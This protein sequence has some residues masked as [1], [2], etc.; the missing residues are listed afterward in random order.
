MAQA[1]R[2]QEV[3]SLFTDAHPAVRVAVVT[4]QPVDIHDI[5]GLRKIGFA[6]AAT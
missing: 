6:L 3:S 2:E 1:E 4:A 5:D